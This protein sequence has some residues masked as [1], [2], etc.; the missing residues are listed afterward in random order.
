[1]EVFLRS[2]RRGLTLM[3]VVAALGVSAG[4]AAASTP[5][6]ANGVLFVTGAVFTSQ[7]AADGN[8]IS[9]VEIQRLIFGTIQGTIT[10]DATTI[11][12]QDGSVNYRE[13]DTCVCMV[14]G[15][16]GIT[17]FRTEGNGPSMF[18]SAG[19]AGTIGNGQG[20][21]E[22]FHTDLGLLSFPVTF[23]SGTYHFDS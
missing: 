12:H 14:D 1:M 6:P 9:T 5:Q 10:S 11:V 22:G 15:R 3:L 17:Y 4:P 19:H 8:L 2:I 21:L 16:A 13:F 23:Y 7:R 18:G 20:G